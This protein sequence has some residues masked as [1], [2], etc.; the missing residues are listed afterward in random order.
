MR[1]LVIFHRLGPYHYARLRAANKVRSL[2]ALE[3]SGR[4]KT[5]AWSP[6]TGDGEFERHVVFPA[7]DSESL[8]GRVIFEEVGKKLELIQPDVVA[9]PGLYDKGALSS[10]M[11]CNDNNVPCILMSDTTERD[12]TRHAW[13]EWIKRQVA[14]YYS[15]ALVGGQ[16]QK[17][18]ICKL[19]MSQDR[20]F[21]GYDVVDNEYF[22]DRVAQVRE[23]A[24]RYR[25]EYSIPERFFLSST[26]FIPRKNLSG[27]ITAY[28]EYRKRAAAP[29]DMVVL[30]DGEL[31]P[32]VRQRV[33]AL[34]M[35]DHVILPGFRQYKELPVYY[36]LASCYIQASTAEPWGLTV[37]EA[38]ASGLPVLVSH[39]CGCVPDL[40]REGMNGFAFDPRDAADVA[41]KMHRMSEMDGRLAT[42]GRMSRQIISGWG[43]NWFAANLWKA[44]ERACRAP[45][46]NHGRLGSLVLKTLVFA[47]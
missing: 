1:L 25:R 45:V 8:A 14:A 4:D 35:Q 46:H 43:C 19:G 3:L 32:Q 2:V 5:Y 29:W 9:I 15:A 41:D 13:R 42:M 16:P 34:D 20:V 7:A 27:L 30:G 39:A 17:N 24:S 22:S 23:N 28:A 11:W 47:R 12:F 40:L 18:Y 38:M 36:G 21:T 10:L 31:M 33:S 37:N 44:A 26:R 6:I